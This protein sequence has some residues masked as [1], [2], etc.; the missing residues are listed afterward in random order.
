MVNDMPGRARHNPEHAEHGPGPGHW[1][2]NGANRF[3]RSPRPPHLAAGHRHLI[4][5][6]VVHDYLAGR[7]VAEAVRQLDSRQLFRAASAGRYFDL[8]DLAD[9]LG[10][11]PRAAASPDRAAEFD[12]EY[13][14]R[15]VAGTEVTD[16]VSRKMAQ[17]PGDFPD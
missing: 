15:F 14:R 8:D 11:A 10:G 13:Q 16:A 17:F 6:R 2:V 3:D 5:L 1:P 12:E 4:A 7:G 9:L